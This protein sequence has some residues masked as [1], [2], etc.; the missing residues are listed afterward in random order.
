[1][2]SLFIDQ[3]MRQQDNLKMVLLNSFVCCCV[4]VGCLSNVTPVFN[5]D[6]RIAFESSEI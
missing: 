4:L 1:M 5:L 2:F 6:I 3:Y